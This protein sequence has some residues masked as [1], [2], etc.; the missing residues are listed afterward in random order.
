M[1]GGLG[2]RGWWLVVVLVVVA[3]GVAVW[4]VLGSGTDDGV[5]EVGAEPTRGT[6]SARA[7]ELPPPDPEEADRTLRYLEGEAKAVLVMHRAA[8]EVAAE[9]TRERCA[10][11]AA[12]LDRDAPADQ[13]LLATSEVADEPLA[14]ALE[15][16][17]LSLGVTLTACAEGG[18]PE[19]ADDIRPLDE[20]TAVVQARLDALAAVR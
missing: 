5:N 16:E 20:I 15:A 18:E 6:P 12:T 14:R 17:R 7:D 1:R 11:V 19:Y 3:A 8:Q 9:P 10:A 13:V 4:I 2:A